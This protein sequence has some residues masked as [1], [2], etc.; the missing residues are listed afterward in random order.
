MD[1]FYLDVVVRELERWM[2]QTVDP[3]YPGV[4]QYGEGEGHC[5]RGES[6]TAERL[7]EI[8][9][10]VLRHQPTNVAPTWWERQ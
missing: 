6:T 5:W 3:H 4:F 9:R 7:K 1:N 8:A 10:H 2:G